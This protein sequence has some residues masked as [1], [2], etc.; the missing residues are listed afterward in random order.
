[1]SSSYA[2]SAFTF[3]VDSF[4]TQY[5]GDSYLN[6]AKNEKCASDRN[7]GD[8]GYKMLPSGQLQRVV[9]TGISRNPKVNMVRCRNCENDITYE[10]KPR[11]IV[12]IC[13][14]HLE[15][16]MYR[17]N[18]VIV[19][20]YGCMLDA[21]ITDATDDRINQYY[22]DDAI[23]LADQYHDTTVG[24]RYEQSQAEKTAWQEVQYVLPRAFYDTRPQNNLL[25]ARLLEE[26]SQQMYYDSFLQSN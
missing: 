22:A 4:A 21:D 16:V 19:S 11:P 15:G 6:K 12:L 1:M 17:C 25:R 18:S 10:F 3:N 13:S 26:H 5:S 8:V 24:D 2:Q 20:Y 23:L 7:A 9:S 14:K